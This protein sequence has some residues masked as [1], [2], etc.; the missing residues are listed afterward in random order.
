MLNLP[1][2]NIN[3]QLLL[4][5]AT[6][7]IGWQKWLRN[8]DECMACRILNSQ[9]RKAG[10]GCSNAAGVSAQVLELSRLL[11]TWSKRV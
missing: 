4:W 1:S 6:M 8:S 2:G 3:L 11:S 7:Y 5:F 9:S 10:Y